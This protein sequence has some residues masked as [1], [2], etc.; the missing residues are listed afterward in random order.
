[1]HAPEVALEAG[2]DVLR[3][4]RWESSSSRRRCRP[5]APRASGSCASVLE[6]A[7]RAPSAPS[8][9]RSGCSGTS[10]GRRRASARRRRRRSRAPEGR[11]RRGVARRLRRRDGHHPASPLK[12]RAL[13]PRG[14]CRSA[15][16]ADARRSAR[17]WSIP[18][19]L[20]LLD[21]A[22]LAH[23]RP[24]DL[25]VDLSMSNGP[26]LLPRRLAISRRILG[27]DRR[28]R[29]SCGGARAVR[30]GIVSARSRALALALA[31][32]LDE[33]ELRTR[34][35][36]V[37]RA[38]LLELR[39][40]RLTSACRFPLPSM[41]M[42]STTRKAA[43]VAEADLPDDLLHGLEVPSSTVP[44]AASADE[45]APCYVDRDELPSG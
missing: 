25:G 18:I 21:E 2:R 26:R 33:A 20:E 40:E 41:S 14:R 43:E 27:D 34:E 44:R 23:E 24:V 4:S 22:A 6:A 31:R 38:V 19:L 10:R 45:L 9:C 32:D 35:H 42:K 17:G 7:A 5:S 13:R 11:A 8:S 16:G 12:Q 3:V 39:L 37:L 28:A 29:S 30:A 15:R 36:P 1:M